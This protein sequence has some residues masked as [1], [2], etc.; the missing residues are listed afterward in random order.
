MIDIL[1]ETK[2]FV[3]VCLFTRVV[4]RSIERTGIKESILREI[5]CKAVREIWSPGA[6]LYM[7]TRQE[8][9]QG[10]V[11]KLCSERLQAQPNQVYS[12]VY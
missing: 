10:E 2:T 1:A 6:V 9:L 5:R 11:S 12:K 7:E 4:V 3:K 8:C